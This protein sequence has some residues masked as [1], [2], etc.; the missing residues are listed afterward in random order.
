MA[1]NLPVQ[2]HFCL[3]RRVLLVQLCLS[4]MDLSVVSDLML[5]L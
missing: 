4:C 1:L 2:W 3:T 5:T